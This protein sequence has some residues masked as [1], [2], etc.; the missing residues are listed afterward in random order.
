[1][2]GLVFAIETGW[3]AIIA[4]A[5]SSDTPRLRYLQSRVWI[6][7]AACGVMA[8]LAAKLIWDMRA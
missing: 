6:D 8:L 5:F 2:L 3:Y 7:R 1:M 4:I